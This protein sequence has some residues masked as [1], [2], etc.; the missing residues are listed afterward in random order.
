MGVLYGLG[1][2]L[3]WGAADFCAALSARRAG[4]AKTLLFVQLLGLLL[5]AALLAWQG[6]PVPALS[7]FPALAG[8]GLLYGTSTLLLYRAMAIGKVS[9][10]SPLGSAYA[11]VSS[12]LAWISGSRPGPVVVVGVVALTA[13][14]ALLSQ[15]PER[16]PAG[17]LTQSGTA[18]TPARSVT[19]RGIPEALGAAGLFGVYFWAFEGPAR[20][21][22]PAWSLL[23]TRVCTALIA[24]ALP[25]ARA[26]PFWPRTPAAIVMLGAAV[27]DNLAFLL[28][29]HGIRVSRTDIVVPLSSQFAAVTVLLGCIYMRE[30]PTRVQWVGVGVVLLG[31][32]LVSL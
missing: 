4:E 10:V 6:G 15:T 17:G 27:L 26:R 13:G 8:L 28:F 32:L 30:R 9:V 31:V 18:D 14:V 1:S 3:S 22:G 16:A 19:L 12:V 25:A 2:A 23:V 21:V 5:A 29:Q 24:A 11:I 7:A 20:S